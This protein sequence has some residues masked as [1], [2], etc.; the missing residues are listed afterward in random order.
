MLIELHYYSGKGASNLRVPYQRHQ[1]L[2]SFAIDS[3]VAEI[4]IF[5]T[6]EI[7]DAYCSLFTFEVL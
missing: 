1:V 5:E 2:N 4:S 7:A 6:Q 3:G